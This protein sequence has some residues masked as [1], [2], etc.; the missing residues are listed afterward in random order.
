[1]A[2]LAK[3]VSRDVPALLAGLVTV[4]LWASAFVGIRA[5]GRTFSPGPLSLLRL[6]VALLVLGGVALARR[7]R[8]PRVVEL[9]KAFLGLCGGGFL[10]FGIYL[11]MLN[12]AER[13]VDAGT[14]AMLVNVGPILIAVL[15]G[16]FLGEGFPRNLLLGCALALCGAGV[17]ALASAT[18]RATTAGVVLCLA[19][20]VAY[21]GGAIGHKVALRRLAPLPMIFVCCALGVLFFL[22]WIGQLIHELRTAPVGAIEWTIY[23]GIFP[24][25]A[26]FLLWA[27]A[28]SR[29]DAG[30]MGALTYLVPP[31]SVM[32][33]WLALGETPAT[34]AYIGGALCLVGVAWSRAVRARPAATVPQAEAS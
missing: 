1:M 4:I 12:S 11:L 7:E 28:L 3:S 10:W 29:T 31:L 2:A 33:G 27:F 22:P 5:A 16:A 32:F 9:R 6:A 23:L 26:G 14:A 25:A 34:L 19:S 15:A 24:T 21:A 8:V 17:I 20:A 13:R 18:H 30:R